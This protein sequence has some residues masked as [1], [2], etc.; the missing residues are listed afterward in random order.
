M[1]VTNSTQWTAY[2][3]MVLSIL[4]HRQETLNLR[5]RISATPKTKGRVSRDSAVGTDCGLD[6][7][8]PWG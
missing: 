8:F 6:C 3:V 5:L 7:L 4:L 2:N 1:V